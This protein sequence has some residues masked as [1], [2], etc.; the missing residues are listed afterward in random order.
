MKKFALL[1]SLMFL[2][3]FSNAENV[4][5]LTRD[6]ARYS[7]LI[8]V[9]EVKAIENGHFNGYNQK[10]YF[11]VIHQL[12][13]SKAKSIVVLGNTDSECGVTWFSNGQY[14]LFLKK[15]ETN[16]FE[17]GIEKTFVSVNFEN[18]MRKINGN[19]IWWSLEK[20]DSQMRSYTDLRLV[21]SEFD[22]LTKIPW[23]VS[24]N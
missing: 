19:K 10:V 17:I 23:S 16:L 14:L 11:E 21:V 13:G 1:V 15:Y 20:P 22:E 6:M 8:F 2:A 4:Y 5:Y 9:G 24:L 3:I 18:G 7:E 12:K